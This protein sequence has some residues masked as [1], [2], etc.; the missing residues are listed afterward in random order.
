M[1]T[2]DFSS[3]NANGEFPKDIADLIRSRGCCVVRGVVSRDQALEWKAGMI[4]YTKRHPGVAGNP[5]PVG[6][7]QIWKVY[8][9][10]PQVEARSHPDV[11]KAQVAMSKLFSCSED[12]EVDL[13][14]QALYADRFRVRYPGTAGKLPAHLDNGSIERWEDE[15]NSKTFQAIWEGR[16]EEYD[17]WDINH[18]AEAAIDLY[19][20][21]GAC[22]VFR[23]IQGMLTR[24]CT[25]KL[26]T[27]IGWL[28]MAD[29]GPNRGTLQLVPDIKLSTAY[30]LLRPFF[31]G[32]GKLDMESTYFYGAEPGMGQSVKDSWHPGLL[33]DKT[34]ISVP[35]AAPG[36]YV[37]WHCDVSSQFND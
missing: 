13:S 6:D 2:V 31:D 30:L 16:W 14:S 12:V 33:L 9:S 23:S 29:N 10:K 35:E 18:R 1:P 28:S 7:P 4:A 11:I 27:A 5:R 32:H 20:G 19:G 24:T 34:I 36:D 3:I 25:E 17:A 21:P 37:F 15:E 26:L 22:S 8:W